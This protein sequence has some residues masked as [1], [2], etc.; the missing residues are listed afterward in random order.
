MIDKVPNRK[1]FHDDNV[2]RA[3]EIV[4]MWRAPSKAAE[5]LLKNAGQ[6]SCESDE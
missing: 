2:Q 4:S 6:D 5:F 3:Q 1:T